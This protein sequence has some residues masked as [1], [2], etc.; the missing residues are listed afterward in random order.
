MFTGAEKATIRE[1]MG[2]TARFAQV[3]TALERAMSAIEV[4]V[5]N[6]AKARVHLVEL[7]RVDAALVACEARFKADKVGSITL[8]DRELDKLRSRGEERLGR[9]ATLLGCEVRDSPF[10]PS[11]PRFR[12]SFDGVIGGG[13][14]QM[15]G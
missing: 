14:S 3:D 1:Y 9:L 6:I 7:A 13:N 10:S 12:S 8:S 2:W 5:D 11:L 4:D 15:M